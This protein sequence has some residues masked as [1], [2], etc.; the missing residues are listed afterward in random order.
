MHNLVSCAHCNGFLRAMDTSC[1]H[2]E[3][4]TGAPVAPTR[5][6]VGILLGGLMA[7]AG[8]AF[9]MTLMACYGGPPCGPYDRR[10]EPQPDL[11]PPATDMLSCS[12]GGTDAGCAQKDGGM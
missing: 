10:C 9:A 12:D 11:K 2:C 3:R 6:G 1:P 5:P 7:L 8:S 4:P